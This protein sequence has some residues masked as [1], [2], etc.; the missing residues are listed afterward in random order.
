[1]QSPGVFL[2]ADSGFFRIRNAD[3]SPPTDFDGGSPVMPRGAAL[4]E[5]PDLIA[6]FFGN[7][8]SFTA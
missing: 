3:F 7:F 1:M 4:P 2:P 5:I 6:G 8:F